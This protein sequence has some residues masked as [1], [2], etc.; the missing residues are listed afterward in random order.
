MMKYNDTSVREYIDRQQRASEYL[1]KR[2]TEKAEERF[3]KRVGIG[4]IAVFTILF[5]LTVAYI[6]PYALDANWHEQY[7]KPAQEMNQ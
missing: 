4:F 7:E 2:E 1:E 3:M 6:L 5:G